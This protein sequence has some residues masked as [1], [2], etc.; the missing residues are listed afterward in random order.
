MAPVAS[1]SQLSH[2]RRGKG[3]GKQPADAE[4][5]PSLISNTQR[6]LP[7]QDEYVPPAQ[8]LS[9]YVYADKKM[10][11]KNFLKSKAVVSCFHTPHPTPRSPDADALVSA[12]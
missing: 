9:K 7:K 12:A 5:E 4:R 6:G 10:G 11:D 3:K 2:Q 8:K 1:T